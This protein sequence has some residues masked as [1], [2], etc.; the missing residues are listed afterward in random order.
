MSMDVLVCVIY[1]VME[2]LLGTG[3][4]TTAKKYDADFFN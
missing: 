4:C 3:S 2:G 1:K